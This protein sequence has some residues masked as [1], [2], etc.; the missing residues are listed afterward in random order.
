MDIQDRITQIEKEIRETPYHKGTEHHIGKLRARIARLEDELA[1]TRSRKT[2]G[3]APFAVKKQGDATIVFVGFPSVGKSTLLNALTS[4]N[5]RV[6]PFAFTTLTVIPG[7]MDYRGARLQI[8]DLPGLVG[9]AAKGKGRGREILSVVRASDL[10][11][12]IIEAGKE[13]QLKEIYSELYQAGVRINQNAPQIIIKKKLKGG[14]HTNYPLA[15]TVAGEFRIVNAEIIIKGQT[16][17]EQIIDAFLGNRVYVPAV[18]V[19]NKIDLRPNIKKDDQWVYISSQNNL[20]LE[21]LKEAIWEKLQLMRVYLKS[22]DKEVD[23]DKPLILKNGQTVADAIKKISTDIVVKEA[24][25][26]GK[27]VK[28]PNQKVSLTHRLADEDILNFS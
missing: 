20:N 18:V 19:V 12:L 4:A 3:G 8:F 16:S 10:L 24:R 25:V 14:I 21:T 23:T 13:E 17:L 28:Y 1:E 6:A 2:G 9:G 11:I 7:M 27:S 22:P 26:S 5:S 15:A